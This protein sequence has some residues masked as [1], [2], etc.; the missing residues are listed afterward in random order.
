MSDQNGHRV[1]L[2]FLFDPSITQWDSNSFKD[3]PDE[4][5]LGWL[6]VLRIYVALAVFLP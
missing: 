5:S 6:V 2:L 3:D 1:P 4:V